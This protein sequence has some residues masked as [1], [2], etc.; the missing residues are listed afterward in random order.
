MTDLSSPLAAPRSDRSTPRPADASDSYRPDIEGLRGIAVSLVVAYHA[1]LLGLTGGYIGVDVFFVLSGYLITG[2]LT[3]QYER[4]GGI[5]M[6]RFYSR[7]VLRLLPA[8]TLVLI[9]TLVAEMLLLGPMERIDLSLS[10]VATALYSSNIFFMFRA[11]DYFAAGAE[12]NPLLHT[13]SLAVEEQFYLVWPLLILIGFKIGRSRRGMGIMLGAITIASFFGCIWLTGVKQPW[14]FFGTIARAWEFGIGGLASLLTFVG[15]AR[16]KRFGAALGW[17][18]IALI[19]AGA[20]VLQPDSTFPGAAAMLPALGTTFALIAGAVGGGTASRVLSLGVLQWIGKRSYSWYLWHWPVL[21]FATSFH[22]AT[23]WWQRSLW[24]LLALGI[25]ALTTALIENPIRFNPRLRARPGRSLL[26]GAACTLGAAAVAF[27]TYR[28]SLANGGYLQ[29]AAD[30]QTIA[31]R[32]GCLA[33]FRVSTPVECVFG[34]TTSATTIVLLGDSHANQWFPAVRAVADARHWRLVTLLKY[35]C[36]VARVPTYNRVLKRQYDECY[37][38]RDSVVA[39]V[40]TLRP[41]AVVLAQFSR[42]ELKSAGSAGVRDTVTYNEWFT[43]IRGAL[44]ALSST[45]TRTIVLRDTPRP[46]SNVPV[47]LSR[48]AHNGGSSDPCGRTR[49]LAVDEQTYATEK[50]AGA[51][52]PNVAFIDL[53]DALCSQ[54]RCDA[55]QDGIVVYRDN[56]HLTRRFALTLN[57]ELDSAL[58]PL[59]RRVHPE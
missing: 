42:A 12:S 43:G 39:R 1:G 18:G 4:D 44:V 2:I 54:T 28:V 21:V 52:V 7:R 49:S 55:I 37:A 47:C 34:D 6:L 25:A 31:A 46:G 20:Y 11:T 56:N 27:T 58:A 48:A 30:T 40:A 45:G 38:W 57:D 29:D 9:A 33:D 32:H 36:P 5:D 24:M 16:L 19:V 15:E 13:W 10:G 14:A 17:G 50:R 3:R 41:A 35:S 26:L 59:V 53:T 8:A 22:Y 51:G 23:G